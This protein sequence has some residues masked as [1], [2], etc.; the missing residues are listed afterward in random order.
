MRK[1]GLI[2][3]EAPQNPAGRDLSAYAV[4]DIDPQLFGSSF[5]EFDD[6][7]RDGDPDIVLTDSDI[8]NPPGTRMVVWYEHPGFESPEIRIPWPKHVIYQGD[9]LGDKAYVEVADMD[10]DGENDVLVQSSSQLYI[11]RK[12]DTDP[13]RFETVAIPKISETSFV[14][15]GTLAGD[16]N[17]DGRMDV[18]GFLSHDTHGEIPSS[19]W[20]I[21]W[22]E[23]SGEELD[24]QW[25]THIIKWSFGRIPPENFSGEKWE[26]SALF[27]VDQDGDLDL[28]AT[29]EE[30]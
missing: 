7:D 27:D 22:M 3:V 12:A 6:V 23:R 8:Q 29:E 19:H 11:F 9:D 13:V 30:I 21:Y 10:D 4:H 28:I 5:V 16:I 24:A 1:A 20:S 15:R 17:N 18:V 14:T 2:W 26:R 25:H